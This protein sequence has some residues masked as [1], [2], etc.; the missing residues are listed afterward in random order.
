MVKNP[1]LP[2]KIRWCQLAGNG[3]EHVVLS[4][5]QDAIEMHSAIITARRTMD[6]LLCIH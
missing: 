5:K 3:L 2:D 6:L 4:E 1:T